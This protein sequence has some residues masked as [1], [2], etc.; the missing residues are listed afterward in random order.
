MATKYEIRDSGW[1]ASQWTRDVWVGDGW[2]V[3][4]VQTDDEATGK[5]L[6]NIETSYQGPN[7]WTDDE[8]KVPD[9]I[10]AAFEK[11]VE[12]CAGE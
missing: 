9:E 2:L 6:Q 1:H 12:D 5:D 10:L 3:R 8:S 11:H 7:G 4:T